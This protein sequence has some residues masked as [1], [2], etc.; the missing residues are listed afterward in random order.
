MSSATLYKWRTNYGGMDASLISELKEM[1]EENRRLKRTFAHVNMQ[2]DL[3]KETL[4]H[5]SRPT[6]GRELAVKAVAV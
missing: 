6:Q 4:G 5:T 3:L 1:A 2:N